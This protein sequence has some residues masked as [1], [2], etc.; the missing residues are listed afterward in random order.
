MWAWAM[1]SCSLAAVVNQVAIALCRRA[2]VGAEPPHEQ[3]PSE[4]QSRR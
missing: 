3:R 4:P 2:Q 1:G